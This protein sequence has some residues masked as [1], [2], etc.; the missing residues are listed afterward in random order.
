MDFKIYLF[1]YLWQVLKLK[2]CRLS[3]LRLWTSIECA[4]CVAV[5]LICLNVVL[6]FYS[7]EFEFCFQVFH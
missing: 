5:M 4:Y 2:T 3:S 1:I 7:R 6:I